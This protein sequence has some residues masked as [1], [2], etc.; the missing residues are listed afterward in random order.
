MDK[1]ECPSMPPH[2][3][4][5]LKLKLRHLNRSK[6]ELAKLL[7]ISR[8]TLY[9]IIAERQCLTP[10]VAL[11]VAKLTA[12]SA[13]MW[14]DVQQ[15]HDLARARINDARCS[16]RCRCSTNAGEAQRR[17]HIEATCY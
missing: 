12:T 17:T 15:A 1:T 14:L 13:K 4:S 9:D 16:Q 8:Q 5:L 10:S 11:R 6:A 2:L 3:G 7:W